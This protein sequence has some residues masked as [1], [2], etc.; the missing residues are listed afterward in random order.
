MPRLRKKSFRLGFTLTE[1]LVVLVIIAVL[2]GL[3]S[4][5]MSWGM[6]AVDD[7]VDEANAAQLPHMKRQ[8]HEARA[9]TLAAVRGRHVVVLHGHA[10]PQATIAQ[11]QQTVPIQV[12]HVYTRGIRGFAAVIPPQSVAAVQNFPAVNYMHPDVVQKIQPQTVP[13]G[14]RRIDGLIDSAFGAHDLPLQPRNIGIG[15]PAR[16][17]TQVVVAIMDSGIDRTH[18]DLNVTFHKAF[19][20]FNDL[21]VIGHGTHVAGIVGARNNDIGVVG[22]CPGCQLW[23]L[24][25]ADAS[26]NIALA[27]SLSALDFVAAHAGTIRVCNMSFGGSPPVPA[28]N[29]AVTACWNLGVVMVAAAGNVPVDAS[30]F[31]PASAPGA[32]C[33][34]ALADSD[35]KPGGLGAACSTGDKDDTMATFS[36]FGTRVDFLAPGVD[37]LSTYP[38]SMG[39]YIKMSGTSMATPHVSGLCALMMCPALPP[40]GQ[41]RNLE[42]LTPAPALPINVLSPPLVKMLLLQNSPNTPLSANAFRIL[43]SLDSLVHPVIDAKAF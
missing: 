25:V 10:D 35:G 20:A 39:S 29:D 4:M 15:I 6:R 31:S 11:I 21:D 28:Q 38:V 34:G 30:T 23:N 5:A 12:T 7:L 41:V 1:I 32:I 19:G 42:P 3:T 27:D 18:P 22:V 33:V 8:A 13:T 26:G 16:D 2:I 37:I 24:K 43:G 14:V 36:N 9:K 40:D 17:T